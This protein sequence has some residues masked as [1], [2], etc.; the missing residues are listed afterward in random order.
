MFPAA[1]PAHDSAVVTSPQR[2]ITAHTRGDKG[3]G[4]KGQPPEAKLVIIGIARTRVHIISFGVRHAVIQHSICAPHTADSADAAPHSVRRVLALT[5]P[6][7]IMAE[8]VPAIDASR[9][10][11]VFL[12]PPLFAPGGLGLYHSAFDIVPQV[13]V[14]VAYVRVSVIVFGRLAF[15]KPNVRV[16][17]VWVNVLPP[18]WG[19]AVVLVT[20]HPDLFPGVDPYDFFIVIREAD[21]PI[22]SWK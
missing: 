4:D 17:V 14:R 10:L 18:H 20:R 2:W 8:H 19:M 3:Q 11:P 16:P 13:E 5:P 9:P 21:V 7:F 12:P 1:A 15:G 6:V 22:R